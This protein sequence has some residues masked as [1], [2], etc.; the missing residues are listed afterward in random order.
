MEDIK[1]PVIRNNGKSNYPRKAKCPVCNWRRIYDENCNIVLAGGALFK[2][3]EAIPY[4]IPVD[5]MEGFLSLSY[6]EDI[7]DEKGRVYLAG[8]ETRIVDNSQMGLFYLHFCSIRCLRKFLNKCI[9]DFE[10]RIEKERKRIDREIL[11]KN[12]KRKKK[13]KMINK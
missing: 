3:G 10:Q 11:N 7:K 1:L 4:G 2:K 6:M 5:Q 12:R 9:D 8:A 13:R